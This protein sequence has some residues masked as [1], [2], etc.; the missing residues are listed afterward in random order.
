MPYQIITIKNIIMKTVQSVTENNSEFIE[1]INASMD[2]MKYKSLPTNRDEV[3]KHVK[4]L[5]DS[6]IKEG[7]LASTLIVV[8]VKEK[9]K[10][11]YYVVDGE[12]TR[13]SSFNL[14]LPLDVKIIKLKDESK[15]GLTKY[16][17]LINSVKEA[18]KNKDQ[19]KAHA[20]LGAP[21]YVEFSRVINELKLSYTDAVNIFMGNVQNAK[22]IFDSGEMQFDEARNYK[23]LLEATL[24]IKE[25][26]KW[27]RPRRAFFQI[28]SQ[29]GAGGKATK[30]RFITF[31]D[32]IVNSKIEFK[33][34]ESEVK[35]QLR[36]IYA[37]TF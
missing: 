27:A 2:Y 18:W 14:N 8:R 17:S 3:P 29:M 35:E 4:N 5:E 37:R 23:E 7:N 6:F 21:E 30:G 11:V 26:I 24:K 33:N 20:E 1:F 34:N 19:V 9:S 36:D 15:K 13:K 25:V 10:Y 12:H 16:V 32:A 31:A 28:A 22:K